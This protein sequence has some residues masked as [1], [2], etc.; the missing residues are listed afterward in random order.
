MSSEELE[1]AKPV[2][3]AVKG[4][5]TLL[6]VS[7]TRDR[8]DMLSLIQLDWREIHHVHTVPLQAV[9]ARYSGLFQEGL[10]TLK[11][12]QAKIYVDT[13]ATPSQLGRSLMLS[14]TKW[15]SPSSM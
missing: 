1:H 13:E 6:W 14:G 10:G 4:K 11:G 2:T 3:T 12:F 5:D 8:F 7:F 9:L 15:K